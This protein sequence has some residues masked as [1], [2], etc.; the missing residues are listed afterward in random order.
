M[1]EKVLGKGILVQ[2]FRKG[3][4]LGSSTLE[5]QISLT[6][7]CEMNKV[8]RN[9]DIESCF[10][11]Q[12]AAPYHSTQVNLITNDSIMGIVKGGKI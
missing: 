10:K 11:G 12:V 3:G 5:L 1:R 8:C 4:Q 2:V 7:I 6:E 9:W